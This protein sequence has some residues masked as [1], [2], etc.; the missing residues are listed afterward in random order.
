MINIKDKKYAEMNLKLVKI[1][2]KSW[3]ISVKCV[4][5]INKIYDFLSLTPVML[6]VYDKLNEKEIVNFIENYISR[7]NKKYDLII[8]NIN[9]DDNELNLYFELLDDISKKL[10]ISLE[11]AS[12]LVLSSDFIN[13]LF[14]DVNKFS[15]G[16]RLGLIS[17]AILK[18]YSKNDVNFKLDILTM[19][20]QE[21]INSNSEDNKDLCSFSYKDELSDKQK[22]YFYA[23]SEVLSKHFEISY[24]EAYA[25]FMT[26]NLYYNMKKDYSYFINYSIDE[27]IHKVKEDLEYDSIVFN[28][29]EDKV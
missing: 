5:N 1:L 25:K 21:K 17:E 23:I 24:N 6:D 29:K 19:T 28:Y 8:E 18:N 22:E 3:N 26:S 14:I 4:L 12:L 2:S 10:N 15:D 11:E 27:I 9:V 7:E 13:L 20:N 16:I